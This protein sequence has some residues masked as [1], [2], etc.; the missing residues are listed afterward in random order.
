MEEI[1]SLQFK[2]TAF[3]NFGIITYTLFNENSQRKSIFTQ[4]LKKSNIWNNHTSYLFGLPWTEMRHNDSS[5]KEK[6]LFQHSKHENQ[7]VIVTLLC[8][9][10]LS[11]RHKYKNHFIMAENYGSFILLDIW[12]SKWR[13]VKRL[14]QYMSSKEELFRIF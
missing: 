13:Q 10:F 4:T 1:L 14:I 8:F 12:L 9:S 5:K 6:F 3:L 11:K 7:G 2:H